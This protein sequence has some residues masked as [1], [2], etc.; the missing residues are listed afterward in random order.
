MPIEL[1]NTSINVINGG[2]NFQ[3]DFVK[4]KGSYTEKAADS[5]TYSCGSGF[6]GRLGHTSGGIDNK[7]WSPTLTQYFIDNKITIID[8]SGGIFHSL[9]LD[10]NGY[11]YSCGENSEG[12]LGH[13][14][15]SNKSIPT[16]IEIYIDSNGNHINYTNITISKISAGDYHSIFLDTNGN[17][18]SCGKSYYGISGH[19]DTNYITRPTLIQ[20]YN[21]NNGTDINYTN[22]TITQISASSGHSMFLD[23][24]GNVY[25]CGSGGYG[26]LGHGNTNTN[27]NY[28]IPTLILFFVDNSITISQISIRGYISIFLD[29]NGYVY[30]CGRNY[31]GELGHGDT[32]DIST[33]TLIQTF[34][35]SNGNT[36][37]TAITISK[38]SAGNNHSMFLDTNGYVYSCGN[39][40]NG[41]TGHGDEANKS[42][43]TLIETYIGV[44]STIINYTNITISQV[45]SGNR[46]TIF[47]NTNSNVYTFGANNSGELGY[48]VNNASYRPKLVEYFVNNNIIISYINAG[49]YHSIFLSNDPYYQ[50]IEYPAQWT[51]SSTDA[52]VYHLGNV[53]IGT[54][55]SNTKILNVHNGINFT[56]DLYINNNMVGTPKYKHYTISHSNRYLPD[57]VPEIAPYSLPN[58]NEYQIFQFVYDSSNN[59]GAGQTE[60]TINFNEETECDILIVGGGG[61]GGG[62]D[63]GGGGGAG[64]L[65]L[66]NNII[67][68]NEYKLLVGKGG[69]GISTNN[70]GENGKDSIF[71]IYGVDGENS[72]TAKGGGGGGMGEVG[73][74]TRKGSDGGSGGGASGEQAMSS[75]RLGGN[76]TQDEYIYNGIKRGFG[77]KGGDPYTSNSKGSAGGGGAGFPGTDS[78]S[79]VHGVP[80]GDGLAI[81]NE[82]NLKTFFNI[83][84][85]SIGEHHT[86][87]YVYF[88]GG[89]GGGNG[90]S[91]ARLDNR[92]GLGGG[93]Q[94]STTGANGTNG[95]INSGGGG[96]GAQYYNGSKRA[97]D[98]GSGVVIIRCKISK[99]DFNIPMLSEGVTNNFNAFEQTNTL[100]FGY[101][102]NYL[103]YN[104]YPELTTFSDTA[105]LI[106][107]YKFDAVPT[108]GATLTNYGSG[109]SAYNATLNIASNGIERLDGYNAQYRYHWKS[110]AASGNYISV[111]GNI[112]QS[113]Y[114]NG[115]T[116]CFWARDAS[117]SDSD[118]T[119]VATNSNGEGSDI[120]IRMH[121]PWSNNNA[122]YDNGNGA[123]NYGRLNGAS[124]IGTNELV[125]WTFTRE[126]ISSTQ[127][128]LKIYKN[129]VMFLSGTYTRYDFTN[130]SSSSIFYIG[131]NTTSSFIFKNKSLE[132]F[133]I[134]DRALRHEEIEQLHLEFTNNKLHA[135]YKFNDPSNLGLDSSS[136]SYDA[137]VYG[138]PEHI[139]PDT[140]SFNVGDGSQYLIFPTDVIKD[141]G[142][143][144]EELA[145]S[146][147]VNKQESYT[148]YATYFGIDNNTDASLSKTIFFGQSSSGSTYIHFRYGSSTVN[149]NT[150]YD[151]RALDIW[152]HY[153]FVLRKDGSNANIKFYVNGIEYT[154]YN[155]NVAWIEL[156]DY[157][158]INKWLVT[159]PNE[160]I[161]KHIRDF[162]VYNTALSASQIRYI[163]KSSFS[164][165]NQSKYTLQF[166]RDTECDILVV[167]GGGGG[168]ARQGYNA[169]G[170]G[171]AGELL[172]KYNITFAA[173]TLYTIAVGNGGKGQPYEIMPAIEGFDSGIYTGA[174][175]DTP[176][177]HSKGG[178]RGAFGKRGS[179]IRWLATSGGSGGGGARGADTINGLTTKY[180]SDGRGHDGRMGGQDGAGGGG[181]GS[182][183]EYIAS[184]NSN[185]Q[186]P[187]GKGYTS[188]ITNDVVT[189]ASGGYG[190]W[191]YGNNTA[192]AGKGSGGWGRASA[193]NET[194]IASG[195]NGTDGIVIIKYKYL[196]ATPTS[197]IT[198]TMNS[199]TYTDDG[200]VY[201]MG[202]VGIG[203]SSPTERLDV[204]GTISATTKSFKIKHPL[205]NN[206]SLYHG[207]IECP[208][209]DNI[210]RGRATIVGG[211]C[212]VDIDRECNDTGG[213]IEGTFET[214]NTDSQLYLQNNQTFDNVKGTIENGKIHIECENTEDEITI[215][216]IVI[217]ERK[218][219]DVVNLNTTNN[220]GK[221]IC[222]HFK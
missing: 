203:S 160:N 39:G 185:N 207:N 157:L 136:N 43:P 196:S 84:N 110:D 29:T 156:D 199:W 100:T 120:Y 197:E 218:D 61:A 175:G 182:A 133:R 44:N 112:L 216:W 131:Y 172:E 184:S 57:V 104:Y 26:E 167:A 7:W 126:N 21:D 205:N 137:T 78:N 30:S 189:Y 127:M 214:L 73:D 191:Q 220:T 147:W 58:N 187:P 146:I 165:Y 41:R 102:E 13:G 101:D 56:G 2:N 198:Y 91:Y 209:Y 163:Y 87:G 159:N 221:L 69:V 113:L 188:Y 88:A 174:N 89:G 16:L 96:G 148:G 28:Y 111:P 49:I 169:G 64:G 25:S 139:S 129:G 121:A 55:P 42:I 3:V 97:G 11:V 54:Y 109:G 8:F 164:V 119:V 82:I 180:N 162:R 95:L 32:T 34:T 173:N 71:N 20:T 15:T 145:F 124:G 155:S 6:Y 166:D 152:N 46:H 183:G 80:G 168:G 72:F 17:V 86:D 12:R 200:N 85:T 161:N 192:I 211:T 37:Y 93:G 186:A 67:L 206:I 114:E 14:N 103:R 222:E 142:T 143:T 38:I 92:G 48:G 193:T 98:G 19:G 130:A 9:F 138:T 201:Y 151:N 217:A 122:Y 60:Y 62:Y 194:S 35:D 22:I 125:F 66:I 212:I 4:S 27:T 63:D 47:L 208:R 179:S 181:A 170:G 171:G 178:G 70:S 76:S 153:A 18:Y 134:Y 132:D 195:G 79:T 158:K 135:H 116:I 118:Y 154:A 40:N 75:I 68:N 141:S 10:T 176:F 107:W 31:Y 190:G 115:H 36:N 202:N 128:I 210:Y 81:V 123:G 90:N 219:V 150:A 177:Y 33:P 50:T 204:D 140:I 5:A 215:N 213:L 83:N 65:V 144:R 53:G 74:T 45:S 24:N 105:N 59:N 23:T 117:T 99:T 108:N 52:S 51:Y 1:D 106:A 77:N 149:I 94:G